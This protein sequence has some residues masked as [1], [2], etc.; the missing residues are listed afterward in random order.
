MN[1][2]MW[3]VVVLGFNLRWWVPVSL[4]LCDGLSAKH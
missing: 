1:G 4:L 2:Y 3:M